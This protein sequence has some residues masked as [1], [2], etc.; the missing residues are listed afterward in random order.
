MKK[1]FY[2]MAIVIV[3]LF[4]SCKKSTNSE[5]DTIQFADSNFE[6][7]IRELIDKEDGEITVE[8]VEGITDIVGPNKDISSISG[9]EHFVNLEN[10]LLSYNSISDI[11]PIEDLTKLE[12]IQ[13]F[14][15]QIVD[16]SPVSELHNLYFISFFANNITDVSAL[17][18]LTNIE[19][20]FLAGNQVTD[21]YAL[22]QNQGMGSG[23]LL[24]IVGNPLNSESIN[25]YIPQLE[26]RGVIV[27]Y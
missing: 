21:I 24:S 12:S 18:Y 23:D 15:N 14:Q 11:S 4:I 1:Y 26:A 2:I 27:V 8:N 9:I 6:S 19:Q 22:V 20:I 10:I 16:L 3:V 25:N 13:F 17:E 7:L 5:S